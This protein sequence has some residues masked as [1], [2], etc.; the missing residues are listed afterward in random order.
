MEK[1]PNAISQMRHADQAIISVSKPAVSISPQVTSLHGTVTNPTFYSLPK[2]NIEEINYQN[3]RFV[4]ALDNSGSMENVGKNGGH[5]LY[6]SGKVQKVVDMVF[7]ICTGLTNIKEVDVYIFDSKS[8]SLPKLS[9]ANYQNYVVEEIL[10]FAKGGTDI[11]KPIKDI[12]GR[13][14]SGEFVGQEVFVLVITDGENEHMT[15]Q[16]I[17]SYFKNNSNRRIFWQFIGLGNDF[18]LLESLPELAHNVG[19][20]NLSDV[21]S[22]SNDEIIKRLLEHFPLWYSELPKRTNS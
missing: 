16:W 3:L 14:L 4:F 7:A 5:K 8:T 20:F 21:Q 10:K 19:F 22:V 17:K 11:S 15:N 13:Y 6:S 18:K 1:T 2:S 9:K 12:D